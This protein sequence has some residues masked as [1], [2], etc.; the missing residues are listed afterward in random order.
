M[1]LYVSTSIVVE[2]RADELYRFWRN[3]E[4]LPQVM[5]HLQSVRMT[6]SSGSHWVARAAWGGRVE[7]DS[8]LI[9]D[10]P[11]Q[12]LAWRTIDGSDVYNA[13]SVLFTS[14]PPGNATEVTVELL[15]EA[16]AGS[17]GAALARMLGKGAGHD[18]R[19]DL[20]AFKTLMEKSTDA[21]QTT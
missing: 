15:Y 16:P 14:V 12:R 8:E 7:W 6:G 13:G 3:L 18:V 2:R 20:Q 19:A 21:R 9:D 1:P 17:V 4:N 11:N 10:V 5:P